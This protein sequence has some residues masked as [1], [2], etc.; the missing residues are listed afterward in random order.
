M[1]VPSYY[2]PSGV[3]LVD[4]DEDGFL[5]IISSL[6]LTLQV[7]IYTEAIYQVALIQ[8]STN[9]LWTFC[10]VRYAYYSDI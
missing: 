5:K 9:Y 6:H 7:T 10:F 1:L 2:V 8:R 3:S 4:V